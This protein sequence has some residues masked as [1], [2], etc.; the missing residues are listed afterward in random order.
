MLPYILL[1][2]Q[3]FIAA[4]GVPYSSEAVVT[5][6]LLM[7]YD[8]L[9]ILILATSGNWLGGMTTFFIGRLGKVEWI[10]K[11]FRV[12][13]EKIEKFRKYVNKYG[14]YFGLMVWVPL[15]GEVITLALGLFKAKPIPVAIF[16]FIGRLA[17]YSLLIYIFS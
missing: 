13:H 4:T 11:W 8:P 5:A 17:R 14:S 3:C 15:I 1:F 12:K 10:E 7:D 6:Y 2:L 9:L 16:T